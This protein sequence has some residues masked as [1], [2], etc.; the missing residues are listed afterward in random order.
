[1]KMQVRSMLLSAVLLCWGAVAAMAAPPNDN[2]AQ[3]Q[4]LPGLEGQLNGTT[5]GATFEPNEPFSQFSDRASVW[6]RWTSPVSGRARFAASGRSPGLTLAVYQGSGLGNLQRQRLLENL[7]E[8]ATTFDATADTPYFIQIATQPDQTTPFELSYYQQPA[9]A[10][11]DFARAITLSGSDGQIQLS[12]LGSTREAGETGL[13]FGEVSLWYRIRPTASGM[14]RFDVS[15]NEAG[16]VTV[17]SGTAISNLVKV[18]PFISNNPFEVTAGTIYAVR[19][20]GYNY[21]GGT[22]KLSY[23]VPGAP[24]FSASGRVVNPAS[25]G[26]ITGVYN[27]IVMVGP[28]RTSTDGAG[29]FN[30]TGLPAGSYNVQAQA[31]GYVLAP[32]FR[33]PVS[34]TTNE[35]G[36]LFKATPGTS[37]PPDN[38]SLLIAGRI[39]DNAGRPLAGVTVVSNSGAR[40]TTNAAGQYQFA[41]APGAIQ[42]RPSKAGYEFYP[43]ISLVAL[44]RIN[45]PNINFYG[46]PGS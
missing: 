25:P 29:F 41:A 5:V 21:S 43:A 24:T 20:S 17:Y 44:R 6:Y 10:N 27:A 28:V 7:S 35:T 14:A 33:N 16:K 26:G 8:T 9:P 45:A 23:S 12:I 1:M 46:V 34:L 2:F 30:V 22:T 11:D 38:G 19:V 42:I 4:P 32:Q 37:Q 13:Q 3:Q 40:V 31:S 36:L 15:G 39:T 18:S